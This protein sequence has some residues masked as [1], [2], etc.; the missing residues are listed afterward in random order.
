MFCSISGE[1]PLEP[2]VS[3]TSGHLFEKRL[4]EKY[5]KD[6]G[7][8]PIS[9]DGLSM[10]DLLPVQANKAL[11]PRP[12][13]GTSIPGL[14]VAFQNEWDEVMLETFT[15]KQHLDTTRQELAQALY[16]HDAACR[17]IARLMQER[18][19][20]RQQLNSINVQAAPSNG[21]SQQPHSSA[22]NVEEDTH[23]T[24]EKETLGQL[25][26][27][28]VEQLVSTCGELSANRKARKGASAPV[29]PSK[30]AIKSLAEQT[31]HSPHKSE[32]TCMA[33]LNSFPISEV[34]VAAKSAG[35]RGKAAAAADNADTDDGAV[36]LSGGAD[37]NVYLSQLDSGRVLAKLAGHSKAITAVSLHSTASAPA[38]SAL[39]SASADGAVKMWRADGTGSG[40]AGKYREAWTY[41]GHEQP[42][43]HSL[44]MHPSGKY[45]VSVGSDGWHFL[46][47]HNDGTFL[48]GTRN[49]KF[50]SDPA[51][52]YTCGAFHPDGLILGTGS[53]AGTLRIWD[54]RTMENPHSLPGHPSTA[55]MTSLAFSENGYQAASGGADGSVRLWDLRKLTFTQ[56][57]EGA[58]AG[59]AVHSVAFD[60]SG[61]YLAAA[62]AAGAGGSVSVRVVKDWSECVDLSSMHSKAVTGVA[63]KGSDGSLVTCSSDRSIKLLGV[64]N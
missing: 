25:P 47:I 52:A 8:C 63:W 5:I 3:K 56:S 27:A 44:C 20:A 29:P 60:T 30:E 7:K 17:V 37:K 28:A 24:S 2:V 33:V 51:S 11:R 48:Q 13:S 61:V 64:V 41:S 22:M 4:I 42:P 9:G 39:F 18:D 46:D 57:I 45:I 15:L 19:E 35:K 12:I 26:D 55:A 6:Q 38:S 54:V 21:N 31:S 1:V 58:G 34:A 16:Q 10:E 59:S 14:L 49:S 40:D 62:G 36:V 53:A 50:G 23:N 43:V 32:V